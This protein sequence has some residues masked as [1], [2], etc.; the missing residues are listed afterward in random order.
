MNPLLES[1]LCIVFFVLLSPSYPAQPQ[2]LRRKKNRTCSILFRLSGR[3]LFCRSADHYLDSH[4]ERL[5][6]KC[7]E[8]T[9]E[10]CFNLGGF[11][12]S[13]FSRFGLTDMANLWPDGHA[14][15]LFK[16]VLF[17]PLSKISMAINVEYESFNYIFKLSLQR[18]HASRIFA[19]VADIWPLG[20]HSS[21]KTST[22]IVVTSAK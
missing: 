16:N 4:L 21:G 8:H 5:S 17:T 15:P 9:H 12:F 6:W 3:P 1:F 20:M 18:R 22:I 11:S 14:L 2:V 10:R 19:E 13:L 7:I